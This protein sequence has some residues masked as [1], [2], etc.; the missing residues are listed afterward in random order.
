MA[1]RVLQGVTNKLNAW[2]AE[3]GLTFYPSKTVS[4][5]FRKKRKRNEE[6]IGIMLKNK[7]V[8][9]KESTRILWMTAD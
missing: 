2:I 7:I 4:M 1:A 6:P 9:S 3:K 8:P 5:T